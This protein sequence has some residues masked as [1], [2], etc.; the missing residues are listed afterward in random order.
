MCE[1]DGKIKREFAKLKQQEPYNHKAT[2]GSLLSI[3]A[4]QLQL[5]LRFK[6]ATKFLN[7]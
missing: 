7:R 4:L 1:H 3:S 6:I 5:P 2:F